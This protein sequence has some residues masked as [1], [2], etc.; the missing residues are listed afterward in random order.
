MKTCPPGIRES[1][2]LFTSPV[3]RDPKK[4]AANSPHEQ[5]LTPSL[6][7]ALPFSSLFSLRLV[8]C[9]SA[10]LSYANVIIFLSI[11]EI[12]SASASHKSLQPPP[13]PVPGSLRARTNKESRFLDAVPC[14]LLDP[15]ILAEAIHQPAPLTL[16]PRRLSTTQARSASRPMVTVTFGIGSAN[17]GN[18]VS[19][20]KIQ[21]YILTVQTPRIFCRVKYSTSREPSLVK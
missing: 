5:F 7:I 12:D 1:E 16:N 17:R 19:E 11:H 20:T 18:D 4:P 13:P 6:E 2:K 8:Y 10:A 14:R 9:L 3:C 15:I 21:S